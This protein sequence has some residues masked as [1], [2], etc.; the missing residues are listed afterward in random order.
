MDSRPNRRDVLKSGTARIT[1]LS[2]MAAGG[3]ASSPKRP[4]DKLVV[5]TLDDAVKSHRTFVGPLLKE[6][7]F[8]ATFFVTHGWMP[9]KENFM[10]WEEIAEI[11]RMGFEIG[12]HS[13]THASVY[14]PRAAS[15][16]DGELALVENALGRVGVP[17]PTSFAHCGN[18]FCPESVQVLAARGYRLA[19]R[20]MQP[21]VK[22]G[23]I[24][25]G[26]LY[27]PRIHHPLLIPTSGD[28]YPDW[29]LDHFKRVVDRAGRGKVVV[30][31]FHGVP[32]K[33]H[34][35]VHTPA[36]RFREYMVYLK[37]NGFK[38]VA[39]RDVEACIDRGRLPKDPLLKTRHPQPKDGK[40]PLPVEMEATRADLRYWLNNMLRSHRYTLE[41]AARAA[42]LTVREVEGKAREFGIL[43]TA[44]PDQ[45]E[46]E[47][48]R[49]LP[50]PGGRH[51]RIGFRDGAIGPMRGTK[52][53]IFA[54]WDTHSYVVV[55]LP[56]AIFSNLGLIWLAHTHIPTFWD[57]K[58]VVLN[59]V[60]W[61]R[62]EDGLRFERTLPNKI[63]IGASVR[64]GEGQA[65]MELWLRNGT[66][67]PL[68]K[69]TTQ[70]CA[71]LKGADGFQEQTND[72]KRFHGPVAVA[73][74]ADG[75]RWI[76]TAWQRH[77]RVWGNPPCP[78]LHSDPV[79]EDC[80]PGQTVRVRGVLRFYE[81]RLIDDEIDRIRLALEPR[82]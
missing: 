60:D 76:L 66:D 23:S 40:L 2:S 65:D 53:S 31:Q 35:W 81:G 72:N 28:A 47:A 61:T 20:G 6:L 19:R 50:Y 78:C 1:A 9:D 71:M 39:L 63:V 36:E 64:L 17:R 58:N 26:P 49:V 24:Q 51:P 10:R 56:E 16:L 46:G 57:D 69:L 34:P 79:L 73:R 21:E 59:N 44:P 32:D 18:A 14:T 7:G 45:P 30:L 68:T 41:E 38:V 27:N 12:N 74:S 48:L 43:A 8:G 29:S 82:A 52:A 3:V 55:D 80:A 62:G 77:G 75:N 15:R 13:W 37:E 33:A 70:V 67:Q 42:G 11:H 54:P 4:S 25:P 22:Y 5:L